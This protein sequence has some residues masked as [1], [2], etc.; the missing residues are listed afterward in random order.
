[1]KDV[2]TLSDNNKYVVCSKT[3][4]QN[5][6]AMRKKVIFDTIK[7]AKENYIVDY[8]P[9]YECNFASLCLSFM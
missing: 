3:N 8:K 2:I 4:Y 1:M 7:E 6:T 5:N 9:L